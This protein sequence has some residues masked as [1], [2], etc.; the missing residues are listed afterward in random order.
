MLLQE[1][2]AS[3][4]MEN[5]L[6]NSIVGH[7]IASNHLNLFITFLHQTTD[8]DLG[9]FY[10]SRER[11]EDNTPT[12]KKKRRRSSPSQWS[13]ATREEEE[14]EGRRK[15][16]L[17][18]E[19]R[20]SGEEQ[21]FR[22]AEFDLDHHRTWLARGSVVDSQRTR[23]FPSEIHSNLRSSLGRAEAEPRPRS[24]LPAERSFHSAREELAGTEP[25]PPSR[26][27]E[28]LR[29]ATLREDPQLSARVPR[30]LEPRRQTGLVSI[31]LRLRATELPF[32]PL[33]S[34]SLSSGSESLAER[35]LE[36]H[37]LRSSLLDSGHA[38][39]GGSASLDQCGRTTGLRVQLRE[40]RVHRSSVLRCG[41]RIELLSPEQRRARVDARAHFALDQRH[42]AESLSLGE[43]S[44]GTRGG[45]QLSGRRETNTVDVRRSAGEI[46][47]TSPSKNVCLFQNNL[48][49]VKLLLN[50]SYSLPV[51]DPQPKRRQLK[52]KSP[53]FILGLSTAAPAVDEDIADPVV[54]ANFS[55]TSSIDLNASDALGLTC[56]HYLVQ[57]FPD[58]SYAHNLD[59]LRL[60]HSAG[61]SLSQCDLAG[62]SPLQ[63]AAIS[64]C[65]HLCD[66][67]GE[68]LGDGRASVAQAALERFDINDPNAQLL[69]EVDFSADAQH[70]IEQYLT[71]HPSRTHNA[72]YQVD[73]LSGLSAIGEVLID[74][75]KNE[76]FDVRLTKTD[77]EYG[78]HGFYNFYRMQ[79]IQHKSKTNLYLLFTR[80]GRIGDGDGQHQL[81]PFST[82]D[83]CR[84]EFGK[85]F[86]EKTANLWKDTDQFQR[87][88]KKYTLIQLN[89]REIRKH[90]DV[91]IDF[92]RLSNEK[93]RPPSKLQSA[94]YETFFE[95]LI[96]PQAI[97]S[98]LTKTQLDVEWM[99]VSQLKQESLQKA[100]D[101]LLKLKTDIEKKQN[102]QL[103]M[104]Q[105]KTEEQ[106][107]EL[108]LLLDSICRQTNEYYTIIPL[109]GYAEEKLPII[110][111]EQILKR[112]SQTLDDILE[113]ELSYKMLL[114]AQANLSKV[115][116][117][118]YLYRSIHCQFE[119]MNKDNIDSQ[120]ILRYISSSA[121]NIRVEQIFKLARPNEEKRLLDRNLENHCL[122]WHGT[123]ICNLISILT[124][125]LLVGP[126]AATSTGSLFGKG[127][128]SADVFAK[129]LGYCSGVSLMEG[130]ERCFMLLC[131]VALGHSK[132]IGANLD[133]PDEDD[134]TQPLDLTLFQSRKVH[135]NTHPD[136]RHTIT[137]NYGLFS[138]SLSLCCCWRFSF[139]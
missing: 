54:P 87:K 36:Q 135:G 104:A 91:P 3:L 50:H 111:N 116:P 97:R 81:T 72:A 83:E 29:R 129:S 105:V 22:P 12:P 2:H 113:L 34:E 119:A 76:P 74:T 128:Y 134:V 80:W 62:L 106:K 117:L 20:Q 79:I 109:I 25:L 17:D 103:E 51:L 86:R 94:V 55:V 118:D 35:C 13:R 8:L 131:E 40:C 65:Q 112:Q 33:P 60:L 7:C 71:K 63:Y 49:M 73:P 16:Y 69:T 123:S 52:S 100:R 66:L 38:G 82:L 85:V 32:P 114:A 26:E 56:I 110:D 44:P 28:A 1:H 122:L 47:Q 10:T 4:A 21:T 138:P 136:P 139:F 64:G 92:P 102:L 67:L 126:L 132:E 42:R 124:R 30:R 107:T 18:V 43:V 68:L 39:H 45:C 41:G 93:H 98:N 23:S 19:I 37:G 130:D 75:E 57:P 89:E 5:N 14:E 27:H 46:D 90:S 96:S 120:L 115:S 137:R 101:I 121:A 59:L 61:A 9:K 133:V 108:K 53:K 70:F 99:P 15:W 84:K 127:I 88:P 24:P 48:E 31:A 78:T 6:S 95:S 58:G 77:V 125:G 11:T